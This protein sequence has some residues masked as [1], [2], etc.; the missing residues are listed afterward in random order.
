MGKITLSR[1]GAVRLAVFLLAAAAVMGGFIHTAHLREARLRRQ[2][3]AGYSRAFSELT[4]CVEGMRTSLMKGLCCSTPEMMCRVCAEV[5]SE[6]DGARM[7]LGMLPF[8]G[9]ELERTA[10]FVTRVGDYCDYIARRSAAGY[11]CGDEEYDNLLA[12]SDAAD[13]LSGELIAA[14]YTL[15]LG[16]GSVMLEEGAAASADDLLP[17]GLFSG[18][19]KTESD[20]PDVPELMYDGPFSR[21]VEGKTPL[22]IAGAEEISEERAIDIAAKY[23][24]LS[25]GLFSVTGQREGTLPVWVVEGCSGGLVSFD[26]TRT[27]GAV[28]TWDSARSMGQAVLSADE[29]AKIAAKYLERMGFS[30]MRETYHEIRDAEAIICFIYEQEGVKIYPDLVKVAV[31]LDSGA[32]SGMEARGYIMNHT[33]RALPSPSVTAEAAREKVSPRLIILSEALAV[34]PTEGKNEVLCYEYLCEDGQGGRCAVYI[35]AETGAEQEIQ[36]LIETENGTL[37]V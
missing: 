17:P 8:S 4:D 36:L 15:A 29:A 11:A 5:S 10:G 23:S 14:D 12:L 22:L 37:A 24:G 16:E 19:Q 30:S 20:L 34:I 35:N 1:R 31:A 27:G 26:I 6:A 32:I 21:H 7:L 3:T 25:P 28:L 13:A 9:G 18:V 33:G 2:I